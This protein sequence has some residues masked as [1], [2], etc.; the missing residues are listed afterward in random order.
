M[1]RKT[2]KLVALSVVVLA[3]LGVGVYLIA[4]YVGYTPPQNRAKPLP[5]PPTPVNPP[6]D[7]VITLPGAELTTGGGDYIALPASKKNV[8]LSWTMPFDMQPQ[9]LLG[10]M[11]YGPSHLVSWFNSSKLVTQTLSAM[12][13]NFPYNSEQDGYINISV[14]PQPLPLADVIANWTPYAELSIES[15]MPAVPTYKGTQ[16]DILIFVKNVQGGMANGDYRF[17]VRYRGDTS[18]LELYY[19]SVNGGTTYFWKTAGITNP[20]SAPFLRLGG[21][22]EK[23]Q[24][25]SSLVGS[26]SNVTLLNTD[27]AS[28]ANNYIDYL[29][30]TPF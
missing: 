17:V 12:S 27:D 20:F 15:N 24:T 28:E 19:Q 22:G 21:I 4:R 26:M 8:I 10:G 30:K 1:K 9:H 29:V 23:T 25:G 7:N 2:G 14:P 6:L 5:P 13:G 3:V 18:T 16:K 11:Y